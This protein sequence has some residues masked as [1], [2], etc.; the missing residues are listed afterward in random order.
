MEEQ[1]KSFQSQIDKNKADVAELQREKEQKMEDLKKHHLLHLPQTKQT[2]PTLPPVATTASQRR[3]MGRR[4]H[5]QLTD[6]LFP[7]IHL[8]KSGVK[9]PDAFRRIADKLGV[10]K[11]TAQAECT[12]QLDHISTDK[13]V[14]LINNNKIKSFLKERFPDKA[15]LIEKEI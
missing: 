7:V 9:H 15:S 5:E 8:I 2:I 13:F 11:Q 4:G 3:P 1:I 6:Y 12:V 10:S 14:E